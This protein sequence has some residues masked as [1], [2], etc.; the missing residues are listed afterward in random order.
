M[1]SMNACRSIG[2]AVSTPRC[3]TFRI[4]FH[5]NG[6]QVLDE[7]FK[8]YVDYTLFLDEIEN[9]QSVVNVLPFTQPD[10]MDRGVPEAASF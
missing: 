10:T 4:E 6:C 9:V 1:Y 8:F 3:G 2:I 5:I 7:Y